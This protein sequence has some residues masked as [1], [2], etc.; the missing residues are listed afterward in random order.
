MSFSRD[1]LAA[2]EKA[3]PPAVPPAV[4]AA[5]AAPD[6]NDT[7]AA[8]APAGAPAAPELKQPAAAPPAGEADP[9]VPGGESSADTPAESAA[10]NADTGSET[11][12]SKGS[13]QER[14]ADL[15]AE[16]NAFRKYGEYQG[17]KIAE[18]TAQIESLKKGISP[19]AAASAEAAG[20]AASPAAQPAAAPANDL[21]PTLEQFDFDLETYGKAESDWIQRQIDRKVEAALGRKEI[22]SAQSAAQAAE[23]AVAESFN[24]RMEDF[25]KTHP[26][27][28]VVLANPALP[29]LAKPAARHILTAEN[30]AA[31]VYHLGKNPDV[32]VR[33][34]RMAP[35]Q[36]LVAIGRIE[37]QL[38]ATPSETQQQPTKQ[39]TTTQAPPPP[40]PVSGGAPAQKS[41]ETMSM[42]EFVQ[43]EREAELRKRQQ[44]QAIRKAVGR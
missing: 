10:A 39:K 17:E 36:Q 29:A 23:K 26:D 21:R 13:A 22:T 18:L 5:A 40:T 2:Y 6:S 16:R 19:A 32:A 15:V 3:A 37:S 33:I 9:A 14:I 44:R 31:I 1:D 42:D 43:H 27:L 8:S 41:L 28:K 34:S 24:A 30:G 7:P 38:A 20:N 35:E 11:P 4:T 25:A 12:P